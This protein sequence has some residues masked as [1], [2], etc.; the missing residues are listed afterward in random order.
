M[1]REPQMLNVLV[2]GEYQQR[3]L[4]YVEVRPHG[5]MP[6]YIP[7]LHEGE[8]VSYTMGGGIVI[9]SGATSSEFIEEL[10]FDP[11]YELPKFMVRYADGREIEVSQST[12]EIL[13]EELM[14]KS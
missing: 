6:R 3:E 11:G 2:N 8:Q 9:W 5:Q 14:V 1:E 12:F 10:R 13:R 4:D 7:K